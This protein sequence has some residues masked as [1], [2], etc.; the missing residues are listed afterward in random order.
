VVQ[1]GAKIQ[2]G[3]LN[4]GLLINEYH[5]SLKLIVT[6]LPIADAE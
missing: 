3:G 5:G 1:T 2:L 4:E 6:K